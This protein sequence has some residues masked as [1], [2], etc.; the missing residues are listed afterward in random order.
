MK[1]KPK[2]IRRILFTFIGISLLL[3]GSALM[4]LGLA[5]ERAT[6]VVTSVQRDEGER[7]DAKQGKYTYRI[8]YSFYLPDGREISGTA[9]LFSDGTDLKADGKWTVPVRYFTGFPWLNVP[10][11]NT[12]IRASQFVLI[13]IGVGIIWLFN[14]GLAA[15]RRTDSEK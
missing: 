4:L 2:L 8:G 11:E 10:E 3:T 6:A 14:S 9:K 5:G 15:R 7:D 13:V 1:R 12:G